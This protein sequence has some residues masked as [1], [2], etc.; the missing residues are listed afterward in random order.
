MRHWM[1]STEPSYTEHGALPLDSSKLPDVD[2][3]EEPQFS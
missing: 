2:M 1:L 3:A